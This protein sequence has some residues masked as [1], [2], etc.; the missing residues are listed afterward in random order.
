M[1]NTPTTSWLRN[2]PKPIQERMQFLEERDAKDRKDGT[3][4]IK[5][6]RQIPPETGMLLALLASSA[7]N[8]QV[9]EIGTSGGYS[10]LWLA[11][12]CRK[13]GDRVTTFELLPDKAD[14]ARETFAKAQVDDVVD[15]V[16]GDA[17]SRIKDYEEVS[18]CFLD[19][20]KEM[21]TEFYDEIVINLVRGGILVA[22]NVVSHREELAEFIEEARRDKN[23]DSVLLPVGKGLL[24]SVKRK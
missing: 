24:V 6:L 3:A 21:Y 8:G 13:R 11:L 9:L 12:A 20:E 22:D 16:H 10:T 2:I 4:H 18:F 17:R 23:M 15:L 7:P 14:I 19:A 5:R 1:I